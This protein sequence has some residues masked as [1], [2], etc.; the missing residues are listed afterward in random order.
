MHLTGGDLA[1]LVKYARG[2]WAVTT[3]NGS[4]LEVW[5]KMGGWLGSGRRYSEL[6]TTT[7]GGWC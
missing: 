7:L 3:V 1:S 6:G 2:T 5:A 4:N